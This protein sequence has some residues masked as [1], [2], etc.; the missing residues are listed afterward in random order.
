MFRQMASLD[1]LILDVWELILKFCSLETKKNLRLVN[2]RTYELVQIF[3]K[4][5]EQLHIKHPITPQHLQQVAHD[6]KRLTAIE[7]KILYQQQPD[8]KVNHNCKYSNCCVNL[9]EAVAF[10]VAQ[11]PELVRVVL[12]GSLD[13][14]EVK[15]KLLLHDSGLSSLLSLQHLQ[16]ESTRR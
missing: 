5:F 6:F 10:M 4:S 14:E 1:L 13:N 8:K 15:A 11:H 9:D 12:S 2:S 3:D 16:D 7:C